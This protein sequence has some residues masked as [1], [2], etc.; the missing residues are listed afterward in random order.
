MKISASIYS[1]NRQNLEKT[2]HELN[3]HDVSLLHV[4]CNDDLNIFDDIQKIREWCQLPIDLHIITAHPSKYY[5]KL[6]EVP[7]EYVTFQ[8]E[9]LEESLIWPKEIKSKKGIAVCT[10]TPI[11]IFKNYEDCDFILIMATV[12]GQSGGAFDKEN[13]RKIR[14]FRNKYPEKSIHVDGGVNGEVSFI[15]RNMGVSTSVSGSYL[16]K[17]PSIGHALLNLTSRNIASEFHI[18]DFMIPSNECPTVYKD[19]TSTKEAL[20]IIEKGNLGFC[21][22]SDDND[23][24]EGIISSA[25]IRK[26]LLKKLNTPSEITISDLLN[27]SPTTILG[28]QTVIELLQKLKSCPFP[29]MYLPVVDGS[30]KILG[31][32]NFANLIKGEL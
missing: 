10:P 24:L 9:P 23:Q 25:D 21:L 7:V 19:S 18:S 28:S 13:F 4:D 17:G 11:D 2:I 12:P 5:K 31:I 8:Y 16:F 29:I 20:E 32:I 27:P 6:L 3:A 22:V 26:A 1:D 14:T 15:L 30:N